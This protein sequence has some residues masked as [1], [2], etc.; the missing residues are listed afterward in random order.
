[1][2]YDFTN[3]GNW[4]DAEIE[5]AAREWNELRNPTMIK[6]TPQSTPEEVRAAWVA[7][8][9]SGRFN[10]GTDYLN[11]DG[12]FCCLGVLCDLAV[13][14]GVILVTTEGE[15]TPI[16][17]YDSHENSLPAAVRDWA[18]IQE[19]YGEYW[20]GA[21]D[22]TSLAVKNDALVPFDKIADIIESRPEGLFVEDQSQ[23]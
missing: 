6:L 16:T 15:D 22:A 13:E 1:V 23:E 14:A 21:D 7:A 18:K 9:R 2:T 17:Y 11:N 12:M 3:N 19:D 8:L 5:D 4:T 20:E 10:Q